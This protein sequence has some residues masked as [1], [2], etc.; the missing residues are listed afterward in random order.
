MGRAKGCK[1]P[2]GSGRAKGSPN[3]FTRVFMEAITAVLEEPETEVKLRELRD[4]DDSTDRRTFW[5]LAG[6]RV[7]KIIEAKVE[8]LVTARIIDLSSE[9][10]DSDG[11]S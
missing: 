2:E 1:K 9:R 3:K 6:N 11:S 5:T 7:P 4:S 8:N 10:E